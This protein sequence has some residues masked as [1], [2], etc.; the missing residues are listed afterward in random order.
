MV[1]RYDDDDHQFNLWLSAVTDKVVHDINRHSS[2]V[3]KMEDRVH[4]EQVALIQPQACQVSPVSTL[5]VT[6]IFFN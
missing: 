5:S 3:G 4:S 1:S 2:R 6:D